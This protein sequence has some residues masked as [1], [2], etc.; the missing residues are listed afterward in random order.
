[1]R[2]LPRFAFVL[3]LTGTAAIA[4]EAPSHEPLPVIKRAERAKV[5][6]DEADKLTPQ[7]EALNALLKPLDAKAAELKAQ[8][9][10]WSTQAAAYQN[11][12]AT[13]E[14]STQPAGDPKAKV[15][16]AASSLQAAANG[17]RSIR[18]T[19]ASFGGNGQ[20]VDA[21]MRATGIDLNRVSSALTSTTQSLNAS[22]ASAEQLQAKIDELENNV[23]RPLK[24]ARANVEQARA[25]AEQRY[26]KFDPDV[27]KKN[28]EIRY[29]QGEREKH[30]ANMEEA[31]R[32]CA[33]SAKVVLGVSVCTDLQSK[34]WFFQAQ[35]GVAQADTAISLAQ[36]AI[37]AIEL[38]RIGDAISLRLSSAA[39]TALDAKIAEVERQI[40][41]L[42]D[43]KAML[44]AI[45][46][47]APKQEMARQKRALANDANA[48]AAAYRQQG[49][50]V[51]HPLADKKQER[52]QLSAQRSRLQNQARMIEHPITRRG[53][54]FG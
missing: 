38:Q 20:Q 36:A 8:A 21:A 19:V 14:R 51:Y 39:E 32:R 3:T 25:E 41:P 16:N 26:R 23:L 7:I 49:D 5:L 17:L 30:S 11:E 9:N 44:L 54:K 53:Q 4:A 45:R 13:L 40:Q 2:S 37:G 42:R 46:D 31:E 34:A 12:A 27:A 33:A 50:A 43:A 47:N 22:A 29:W 6:R 35:A 28:D 15:Q 24:N 18:D 48:K 52:D 1:M 10:A